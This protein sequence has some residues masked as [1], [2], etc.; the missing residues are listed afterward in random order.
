MKFILKTILPILIIALM[1]GTSH[2][3]VVKT[4]TG[5]TIALDVESSETIEGVKQMIQDKEGIT[6]DQQCL[7]FAGKQ[8]EDGHTLNDY[9]IK[10]ESTLYLVLCGPDHLKNLVKNIGFLRGNK[11]VLYDLYFGYCQIVIC[12]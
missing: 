9:N 7:I 3:I 2:G 11:G 8:L 1:T 6:P 10:K 5:K 12:I 4:L